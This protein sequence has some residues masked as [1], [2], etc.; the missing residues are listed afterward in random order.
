MSHEH[1]GPS[2]EPGKGNAKH[3]DPAL[4]N[5]L[6]ATVDAA[7]AELVRAGEGKSGLLLSWAGAAFGVLG[8]LLV[9]GPAHFPGI[10]RFGVILAILLLSIAVVLVL[11]TIRPELPKHGGPRAIAYARAASAQA[12]LDQ[13]REQLADRELSLAGDALLFSRLALAKH[14]YLRWA[15]DLIVAAMATIT[16]TVVVPHL[17]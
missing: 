17:F 2:P 9:T 13:V 1:P 15:V 5:A 3:P 4:K 12:V 7:H 16:I 6:D 14:R 11:L 8:T 10:A